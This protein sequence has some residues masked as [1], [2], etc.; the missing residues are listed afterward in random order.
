MR[1]VALFLSLL[2]LAAPA[3]DLTAQDQAAITEYGAAYQTFGIGD[4]S[5]DW[6]QM[7]AQTDAML[8]DLTGT[9]I[10]AGQL[11]AGPMFNLDNWSRACERSISTFER[12]G[13]LGFALIRQSQDDRVTASFSYIAGRAF[14]VSVDPDQMQ[15]FLRIP[16]DQRPFQSVYT[17]PSGYGIVSVF[18]PSPLTMVIQ[19]MVGIA[20]IYVR[21]PG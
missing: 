5:H 13:V 15:N 17:N 20:D 21:C 3:Q 4:M 2:P 12:H 11:S 8:T 10:N 19:P 18:H 9:W 16:E 1:A 14:Q 7:V 6:D